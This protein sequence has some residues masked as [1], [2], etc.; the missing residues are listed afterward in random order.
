MRHHVATSMQPHESEVATA[1]DSTDIRSIVTELEVVN[2]RL[3]VSLLA[4]P[5]ERLRPGEVAKPVADEVGI[6]LWQ[7]AYQRDVINDPV[8]REGQ[9]IRL[10]A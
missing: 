4:R 9:L 2:R 1:L 3:L 5:L 10:T 8:R 7:A 6:T